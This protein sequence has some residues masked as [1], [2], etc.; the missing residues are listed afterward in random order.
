MGRR[1]PVAA[2]AAHPLMRALRPDKLTLAALEATLALYRDPERA[3]ARRADAP[4]APGAP[5]IP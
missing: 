1:E 2:C 3:A 4:D 5:R